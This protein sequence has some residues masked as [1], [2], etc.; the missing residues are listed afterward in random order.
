M[1][2]K[3]I[4]YLVFLPSHSIVM[5]ET[6][7]LAYEGIWQPD[8]CL[9]LNCFYWATYFCSTVFHGVSRFCLFQ[10]FPSAVHPC[11]M[12]DTSVMIWMQNKLLLLLNICRII[13]L[14]ALYIR[15]TYFHF[16]VLLSALPHS[17]CAPIIFFHVCPLH[18]T[19]VS[20]VCPLHTT[21]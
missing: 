15:A 6:L 2:N 5:C 9:F 10:V 12:C 21:T 13:V 17:P 4:I 7:H 18:T 16:Y 8:N 1:I 20:H 14:R 3:N 11:D 19:C